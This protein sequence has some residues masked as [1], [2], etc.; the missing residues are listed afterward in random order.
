MPS[1]VPSD[2]CQYYDLDFDDLDLPAGA[3]VYDQW[4][5][6]G[7]RLAA[8]KLET[9]T[10]GFMPNGSPRLFDTSMATNSS[11]YGT[12]GLSGNYGNVLIVQQTEDTSQ[13][14]ANGEGGVLVFDFAVA[15]DEVVEIGLL[16]VVSEI[17]VEVLAEDGSSTTTTVP[18]EGEGSYKELQIGSS[19]TMQIKVGFT[20]PSA[21]THVKLCTKSTSSASP[22]A[23]GSAP[24]SSLSLIHI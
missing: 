15:V 6:Y 22:T 20:G 12:Q 21:V 18:P 7:V 4:I 5:E 1:L 10:G 19:Q 3:Y 9:T 2:T 24:P 11:G 8:E 16:N 13:W 17:R 14:K 23:G